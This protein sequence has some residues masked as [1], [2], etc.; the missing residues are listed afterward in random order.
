[1]GREAGSDNVMGDIV[2]AGAGLALIPVKAS[3][4][5]RAAACVTA[6][7]RSWRGRHKRARTRKPLIRISM[8]PR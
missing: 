8:E 1:M 7:S 2:K 4:G 5:A 3:A 6:I